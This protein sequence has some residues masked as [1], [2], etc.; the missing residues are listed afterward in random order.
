MSCVVYVLCRQLS[1]MLAQV[2]LMRAL[3]ETAGGAKHGGANM[4]SSKKN[5]KPLGTVRVCVCVCGSS[6]AV[7]VFISLRYLAGCRKWIMTLSCTS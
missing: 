1:K 2:D 4:A 6:V 3:F 7:S 5:S